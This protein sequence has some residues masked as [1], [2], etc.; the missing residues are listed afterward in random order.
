MAEAEAKQPEAADPVEVVAAEATELEVILVTLSEAIP[1]V[2]HIAV[3]AAE[4]IE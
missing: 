2:N 4:A 3:E 1:E